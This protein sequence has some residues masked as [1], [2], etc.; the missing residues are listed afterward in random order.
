[1]TKS[2]SAGSSAETATDASTVVPD[3]AATP[4]LPLERSR[5][6]SWLASFGLGD[7]T[8]PLLRPVKSPRSGR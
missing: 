3:A 2:I 5:F 6:S 8:I 7:T 4:E 1:M